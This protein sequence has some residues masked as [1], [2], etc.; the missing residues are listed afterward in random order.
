MALVEIARFDDVHE[1][2]LAAAFLRG[3]GMTVWLGERHQTT[4]DP[5]MQR[6]LGIRLLG[7]KGQAED[8]RQYL[9][10]VRAGDF[11]EPVAAEEDFIAEP[12]LSW[13]LRVLAMIAAVIWPEVSLAVQRGNRGAFTALWFAFWVVVAVA[14]GLILYVRVG[15][16]F[17]FR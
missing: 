3:R 16:R 4:M 8:A 14:A 7:P 1:A 11:A 15:S 6:A 10:R 5:L 12:R 17:L 13:P 2:E 9:Q